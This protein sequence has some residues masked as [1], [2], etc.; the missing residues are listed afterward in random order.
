MPPTDP[1]SLK[2]GSESYT[3]H[4]EE[5][6][7]HYTEVFTAIPEADPA[8]GTGYQ[9]VPEVWRTL[10][11]RAERV[12]RDRTG[13]NL[14]GH[15]IARLD[16]IPRVDLIS[17]GAGACGIELSFARRVRSAA[18]T[19]VDINA[20]LLEQARAKAQAEDLE[21]HF[22]TA[23]LN[24]LELP[25]SAHD[26]VFC[27]A[28]LHHVIELEHLFEQ[29]RRTLRPDGELIVVDVITPNGYRMRPATR[30]VVNTLWSAIPPRFRINHTA[31]PEPRLD[32]QVCEPDTSTTSM[33]CIRSEDILPLLNATFTSRHFV[34]FYSI[35]RRFFDTMYGPNY[36]LTNHLDRAIFEFIWE[37]DQHYIATGELEPETFF[38]IY[39]LS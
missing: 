17:L 33:E 34:P 7:R 29:I 31:Y 16:R 1:A 39:G 13:N 14:I 32:L 5:E 2:V 4:L 28:A 22:E 15:V 24:T 38:G 27:H 12:I 26:I 10:E 23:D 19:C 36:E 37:L 35:S 25:A 9:P 3:R 20:T 21:M 30:T 6:I 8:A 11:K 18:I